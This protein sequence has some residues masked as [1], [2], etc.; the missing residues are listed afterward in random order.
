MYVRGCSTQVL[1]PSQ[2]VGPASFSKVSEVCLE[3][4]RLFLNSEVPLQKKSGRKIR[5]FIS[6][7]MLLL[8]HDRPWGQLLPGA[9]SGLPRRGSSCRARRRCRWASCGPPCTWESGLGI[10]I[11]LKFRMNL[12]TTARGAA[13]RRASSAARCT[14]S[15]PGSPPRP[16]RRIL[17]R[18]KAFTYDVCN[19]WGTKMAQF[20]DFQL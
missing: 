4:V 9:R 12:C 14:P 20:C 17:Q 15:P 11:K 16:P 5:V 8:L 1:V 6:Q 7:P 19:D 2:S 3:T 18:R 13:S 10:R